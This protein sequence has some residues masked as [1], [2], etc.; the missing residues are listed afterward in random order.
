MVA[1]LKALWAIIKVQ[2]ADIWNRSKMVLL[3]IVAVVV[4][5][6]WQKLKE[7]LMVQQ[8]KKELQKDNKQDV[9]LASSEAAENKQANALIQQAEALPGQEQPVSDD[10]N[11]KDE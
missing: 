4:A 2:L 7:W 1:K 5:I 10:W 9:A 11:T 6:E 3:A 8:G